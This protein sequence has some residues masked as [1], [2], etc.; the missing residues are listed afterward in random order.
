V[1]T[2]LRILPGFF[3][4]LA[5]AAIGSFIALVAWRLPRGESVIRP[6]SHCTA[7][8]DP[9]P[10]WA[11]LPIIGY[12]VVCGRCHRC[13]TRLAVRDLIAEVALGCAA[14]YLYLDFS[15][16]DA[17][18]RFVFCAALLLVA[19]IDLATWTIPL[20]I[21]VPGI[22]L[23]ISAAA[24]FVTETGLKNSL[25][26][27]AG[28]AGFLYLLNVI[29]RGLRGRDGLGLGDVWLIGMIGAFSGWVGVLF[30][31]FCGSLLGLVF[32]IVAALAGRAPAAPGLTDGSLE[33]ESIMRTAIPFGPFLALAAAIFVLFQPQLSDWYVLR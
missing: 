5:G 21:T 3:V 24:A 30:A 10:Y 28:G 22:A 20:I 16:F 33:R 4:F 2:L 8:G 19:L 32:G 25:L 1:E 15:L 12:L 11:N 23:G 13:G 18:A 17:V 14:L 7:C 31:L 9:V 29:Y 27:A 6:G 26:G